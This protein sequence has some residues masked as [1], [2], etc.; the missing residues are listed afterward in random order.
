MND[1]ITPT[2][3]RKNLYKLIKKVNDN[4]TPITIASSEKEG[5]VLISKK[6]WDA[7]QETMYLEDNGVGDVVRHRKKSHS[8]FTD[9]EDINWDN[10]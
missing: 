6:D 5:A 8:G 2:N 10:L 4:H 3:A 7:I 1:V 9:V